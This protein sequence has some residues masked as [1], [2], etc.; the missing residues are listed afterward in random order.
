MSTLILATAYVGPMKIF[1]WIAI[2]MGMFMN[3]LYNGLTA[4]GIEN[5][6]I[7]I[8]VMTVIIY[9]AMLPL[10]YKQQ[11]FS[12]LTQKM[13]PELKALQQKYK[14]RR[15]PEAQQEMME[16]QRELYAKYGVSPTGSCLQAFLSILILFPLYRVIY[17]I[18]AYVHKVRDVLQPAVDGIMGTSG[19]KS[20]FDS[21]V[22]TFSINL[23]NI[24]VKST[25]ISD[26]SNTV[27][28][29]RIVDI[30]YKLSPDNWS[31]LSNAFPN[32]DF[33]SV[34]TNFNRINNFCLLNVTNSPQYLIVHGFKAG[35][36][37]IVF[38]AILIPALAGL[39]QYWNYKLAPQQSTGADDAMA[40]QMKTMNIMMPLMSVFFAITLPVGLGIYWIAG[41]VIRSIYMIILNRHFDNMDIDAIIEQNQKKIAKKKEKQG[42]NQA[43]I[44]AAGR[45]N[46]RTIRS[47]SMSSRERDEKLEEAESIKKGAVKGSMAQRAAMVKEFNERNTRKEEEERQSSS[48]SQRHGRGRS[49]GRQGQE[50]TSQGAQDE[51]SGNTPE[52]K[53]QAAGQQ[54]TANPA[55]TAETQGE[56]K[57]S[58]TAGNPAGEN[59]Q[60]DE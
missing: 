54:E 18:P 5:I 27:I 21:V 42:Y 29:K 19:Y 44:Q 33:A 48:R 1:G 7:T 52:E 38:L 16:A 2:L 45:V 3:L 59:S 23:R 50:S 24:G 51:K 12:R 31:A 57:P 17:N 43:R 49:R 53:G 20:T 4:I 47:S 15:D 58:E 14:D 46:T 40:Q 60:Q 26:L 30:L 55:D 25:A 41:A 34:Q 37:L 6:G 9:T 8:I 13:N 11:K 10:T 32:V 22:S 35:Q 36:Y 39:T 56:A 28:P